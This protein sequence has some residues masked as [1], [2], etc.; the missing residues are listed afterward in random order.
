MRTKESFS[1]FSNIIFLIPFTVALLK[2]S[3]LHASVIV[4]VFIFSIF[5]HITKPVGIVS[6]NKTTGLT[7]T[8][9]FLLWTDTIFASLLIIFNLFMFWQEGFSIKFWY[10]VPLVAI[11]LTMFFHQNDKN[12]DRFQGT[13]H[14]LSGVITFL[15]V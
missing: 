8:Q 7:K 10:A 12:Y 1:V 5:F 15:A 14:I 11:A 4:L 13:W 6:W 3:Y 9:K 2:G